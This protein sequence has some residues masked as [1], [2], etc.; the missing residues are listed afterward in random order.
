MKN[1][2][3]IFKNSYDIQNSNS[4]RVIMKD[5]LLKFAIVEFRTPIESY[6]SYTTLNQDLKR[7]IAEKTKGCIFKL[8]TIT[9]YRR[10]Q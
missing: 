10:I 5:E 9:V 7:Y 4:N 1:K 6:S 8:C 3:S 2:E